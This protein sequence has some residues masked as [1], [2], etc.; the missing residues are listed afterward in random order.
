LSPLDK[1]VRREIAAL[2]FLTLF[3]SN[4]FWLA[5]NVEPVLASPAL[6]LKWIARTPDGQRFV[7][8]THIG[9]L[10]ANLV[11]DNKLEIVVTGTGSDGTGVLAAIDGTTGT[12]LWQKKNSLIHTHCPFD[13]VDLN[14]D[15]VP[16]IIVSAW[17][18]YVY[19]GN[20]GSIYWSN[21]AKAYQNY[22]AIL[23]ID[24]DSYSEVFVSSGNGKDA[25]YDYITRLSYDGNVLDQAWCW[26]PCWGGV[27]IGDTNFDGRF[28]LYQGDRSDSYNPSGDP[29]KGGGMGVRALDA[30]TLEPLWNDPT[31]LC[32]SQA[33]MLADVDK[34]GILDVIVNMQTSSGIAVLNSADGSVVTT[35]GIYRKGVIASPHP[36]HSQPTVYDIDGDGNL[37]LIDCVYPDGSNPKIWDLYDWKLDATLP[38]VCTEP[39]KIGEVTGDGK[40][41]IIAVTD[42]E[43]YVY[44]YIG[45]N[46]IQVDYTSQG[47]SW[48]TNDFTLV[49]DVDGDNLNE[50]VLTS[51]S[52]YVYCYDTP[53]P[54]PTPRARSNLQFY[55]EYR[56]GAAEYVTPPTPSRPTLTD[57]QPPDGSRNQMLN[58]TLS[59]H[60]TDFQGNLMDIVIRTNASGTWEDIAS[61]TN[62]GNGMYTATPSEMDDGGTTYYWSVNATNTVTGKWTSKTYSFTTYSNAPTHTQPL[63]VSSGGTNGNKDDLTCYNQSTTDPDGNEVTNIYNWYVNDTSLTNLLL[64]FDTN[65]EPSGLPSLTD[66]FEYG[67]GNWDGNGITSWVRTTSQKHSGSYSAQG[68][69]RSDTD[70]TSDDLDASAAEWI[71]VSFWYRDYG[72]D[73]WDLVTLQFWNGST[74]RDILN[75]GT[76][77]P[78]QQWHRYSVW[79][80]TL[81]SYQIPDFHIRFKATDISNND[82]T[83]WVDDVSITLHSIGG[84]SASTK[85]YSGYNN[86]GEV[87]GATWTSEGVIGGAYV[88]DGNDRIT[89]N[90]NGNSLGGDGSWSEISVEFW[91]RATQETGTEYL[92]WKHAAAST[93]TVGYR[94]EFQAYSDTV[95]I[96]WRVY[97]PNTRTVYYYIDV[98]P[99]SW[100]H[101][102]C[103]YKSGVEQRIYVDGIER[104]SATYTG[105]I[106][107]TLGGPIQIG[108]SSG[109]GDFAGMLDEVRIYPRALTSFQ[110]SQRFLETKDGLSSNS[111]ILWQETKPSELW[112]CQVTPNDGLIDGMS[113]FSNYATVNYTNLPPAAANPRILPSPPTSLDDLVAN[114]DYSDPDGDPEYRSRIRWYRD[115][116]LQSAFNNLRTVPASS[117]SRGQNWYFTV[118][119]SDSL[120]FGPLVTS[121]TVTIQNAPPSIAGVY[122]TPDPAF[123]SSD[124]TANP[125]G[126]FD[127][128]NDPAAYTYKWQILDNGNWVDIPGQTSSTLGSSYSDTGDRLKVICTPF[129]G[130]NEGSAR[131]NTRWIISPLTDPLLISSLGTNTTDEY[132]TCYNHTSAT[133]TTNIYNWYVNGVPFANL[134]MPFN[135]NNP[136]TAT[137][138][139]GYSN[140]GVVSGATW[141]SSGIEGGAYNFD[142]NDV[143]TVADSSSLGN[144][145]T[146]SE[147]TLEYWVNPSVDQRG[148]RILNKNGGNADASGKYMTGF[149][150]AATGPTNVVF[151]GIIIGGSYVETYSDT[152]TKIPSGSW[153]HIVATYK[154]G[155]GIKIYI[156]G[157]LKSANLGV[158]GNIDSSVGEPLF[159]GYS[160]AIGGTAN[161]YL[162][163]RLDDVRIYDRALSPE[164]ALQRYLDSKDGLIGS[165]TIVAEETTI[166]EVWKC[167]V[168]P[169]TGSGDGTAKFSNTLTVIEASET[170]TLTVNVVGSGSVN[171]NNT[172]PYYYG[173]VVELTAVAD[174]GWSFKNWSV[175]LSGSAN[176]ETITMDGDKV[177]NATFIQLEYTLAINVFGNGSVTKDPD[178][179]NYTYG[180]EV[181]L[182]AVADLGW[183]FSEWTGDLSGSKNPTTITMDGNKT[184]NATF[185]LNE[186]P[187]IDSYYPIGDP[188]ITE[189]ESQLFNVTY[190]DADGNPLT[191]QWYL[192][193]T[194]TSTLDNYTFVGDYDSA[195]VYNVTV[196]V[197]DGL[198][199]DSYEWTLTVLDVNRDP[200]IDDYYPDSDPIIFEGES[201]EFN[202]TYSDPDGDSVTV[203]WYLNGT[204]TSTA[205]SYIFAANYNSAGVYNVTV[206]ISDGLAQESHEW[207]LTVVEVNMPPTI[208][209]YYPLS[210]PTI[211]EGESQ[212][213][214]VTYHDPDGD[215]VT[216]QWYLNGTPTVTTDSY[217]FVSN[218]DSAG[219]YNVTVVISD[220]LAQ[221]SYEW[222]LTVLNVNR[223]P[224]ID[225]YTPAETNPEVNEGASLNFTHVSSDPD[226]DPLSYS[227]LLDGVE[228]TTTQNWTYSP[229]Y[230]DAGT[231]NITLVVSDGELTDS[232]Q[233]NVTVNDVNR[234]PIIDSYYPPTNPTVGEGESQLF[235][236]TYS[237]PDGDPLTVQWLL[238]GTIVGS[239]DNF[240]YTADY[241]SAGVYNVTV[242]VSDGF[243]QTSLEWTLTVLIANRAPV[244]DDYYPLSD[245]TIL[246]GESQEFN[247]TYHDPDGDPVTVQWL[248]N[249]TAVGSNNNYTFT[250]DYDSAGIYNVTVVV[251]DGLE[252]ASHE[253]FL[254]VLNVNRPPTIDSYTPTDLEPQ[255]DEGD[256]LDFTHTSSDPDGDPLSY[257]W[258]LDGVEQADKQNWTYTPGYGDAGFHNV[259]LVVSDGELTDSQQWNVSVNDVNRPPIIDTYY[260]P[261]DPTIF[262]GQNQE[263]NVTYHDPDGGSVTVQWYLNGTPTSTADNYT[264]TASYESA[265][266]YNI[267]VVISD[268]LVQESHEWTLTVVEFNRPPV[269]DDYYPLTD[270]AILENEHQEFNVTYHDPDGDALTVGWYLN[271]SLVSTLDNYTFSAG[272]HDAGVY[273]VTV[274]V[275]DALA[276]TSYEWTLTVLDVNRPPTIDSFTPEDLEPE[277]DEGDSLEFAHTSSDPDDDILTYSWLLDGVEQAN[278]QN[279]TYSPDFEDAGTHNVTL[280]VSDGELTDSQQ[281]SVTVMNINKAPVINTFY[282][283]TDP[284]INESE[285]Q[286]FNITYSDLD[287]DILWVQ[288]YLNG[289]P[290]VTADSYTFVADYDSAGIYNVTVVVSDGLAQASHEW[291]LTILNV[292]RPPVIDSYTPTDLEP[293]VYEGASLNFTHTSSDPDGDPLS[294]SWLL[295]GVEQATSQ[296]WTY[297]P[298]YDAAGTHNVTLTVSDGEFVVS[299]QWNVTVLNIN[300]A[301]VIDSY[302]PLSNPTILEGESQYF[303]VTYHDVDGDALTVQWLLNGSLVGSL[304][305]YT[306]TAGSASA[307]VYNVTVVVSDGGGLVDSQQWNLIVVEMPPVLFGDGFESGGFSAWDSTTSGGNG[308]IAVDSTIKHHGSYSSKSSWSTSGDTAYATKSFAAT[309]LIYVRLYFNIATLPQNGAITRFLLIRSGNAEV[310]QIGLARSSGGVLYWTIRYRNNGVVSTLSYSSLPYAGEWVCIEFLVDCSSANGQLDGNYRFYVN[311]VEIWN[312]LNVDTD[313]TS[314]DSIR[315]GL[316]STTGGQTNSIHV[317]CVVVADAYIGPETTAT[318]VH[319]ESEEIGASSSNR[320]FITFDGTSY[321]LPSDVSKATGVYSAGYFADEGYVFDH[322]VTTGLISVTSANANPTTVTVSGNGM[323][324][325]IYRTYTPVLFGDGFE[326]GGF[327]A[328]DSTTSGGNGVIAVDSTIKHHG[329]YSSKSSWSASG[330]TAYATKSFAATD[331][332]YVRLY[333]NIATL[334]Q[335]GAIT[336]FLLIRSGNAEVGQIGLA[337][338]SGGVLYWTIRY[339]NNGVVSTLSYSSLPYAGEWVCIEFLVDCS[340]ANGQLDGNYR[341]YVNGVEIWNALNVDTDATSV[342][343]IRVGLISTTDG[344]TNSVYV[345][346][347]VVAD[348]YIGPE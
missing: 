70:L 299:Q 338:S 189:E 250:A 148:A 199:Q 90:E 10:A 276:V 168:T 59:I 91:V 222:S 33:P 230:E 163:G 288:W 108:Y 95:Y 251:S 346:C 48:G 205:D 213:F 43:I 239:D 161:R 175:D 172:G 60:A 226:G 122:I 333:F 214:N 298:S 166:G 111:T 183:V 237:D 231:H 281:W 80:R 156:N 149:N 75:L 234:P 73:F 347:V 190:S 287:G 53:A 306:F 89:V 311:G 2:I 196:V 192:N 88:F 266:T 100:H 327:S 145:G 19:H 317:D 107:A 98:G 313:A 6:T 41:D 184:V 174:L 26:H 310:G 78:E 219:I 273:N 62:V 277:V 67:F 329:S 212:E 118:E 153:S 103:T 348:T 42:H 37:E 216:V 61:Y 243:N 124:L 85:D 120:V 87:R 170:Y 147:I 86:H 218:Y 337:R 40:M 45:G 193:G 97:N 332:I 340:S 82:E 297:S 180:T 304:D 142:G 63:L 71:A 83:F 319:L 69:G 255:V 208:D 54:A 5:M 109:S 171:L 17:Y 242:V 28:E 143:I 194:P 137:D 167:L 244:I 3:L 312:A 248:L 249:G 146:W 157:V 247:V 160:S 34:D 13:I 116:V 32:S 177:V 274:V 16:E 9:A 258:L 235:N 292:N 271:G 334:P 283:L 131:E 280:V 20:D 325:A 136:S 159:I 7:A 269:I 256:S 128:D 65:P 210:D 18:T 158:T 278:T 324:I 291:T 330:D 211:S 76:T 94:V 279:W 96:R 152:Y 268:G 58:P 125:Y 84:E 185:T 316:I 284:T 21:Y 253:W 92:I 187:A 162:N 204:P 114:Y 182:T 328:W 134:L 173:D 254:T 206:L 35:G 115:G 263:F 39:P 121:P 144:D 117:I 343:S 176:P 238:N 110:V 245:L 22:N 246:E 68:S 259:T 233:W 169:N 323:L 181:N 339:R 267:T 335:N 240:T 225:S 133:A 207:V 151:F 309:D 44:S 275:S 30:H 135:T 252:K 241:D 56:L 326:S 318:T 129:D 155:E 282:P 164:Q 224:T 50:L 46:Y 302:Y 272:Y 202:V 23:D 27:T 66:G 99:R 57:E 264:F 8:K 294:Y 51:M 14:K 221:A 93:S 188:T 186:P 178:Q 215:P 289:T 220:G 293:E 77:S 104:V 11:G 36:S 138:Y 285:S 227:W 228:Q 305:N 140:N 331:L 29:Y 303:N 123:D 154:S 341:F 265:G 296:N 64:P 301:P 12:V 209:S 1:R 4:V 105:N 290:T 150:T 38:V 286:E 314:V 31:I 229:S 262:E 72:I 322:W 200:T 344:Q 52:G 127:K 179:L 307:G 321:S 232:Q 257:S 165:S 295:D 55:S 139:S 74:Y 260:P 201:Q 308:V 236:V 195:G 223:P 197:S 81:F 113:K 315:V 24:G 300:R 79:Y 198:A 126:W 191:V 119:P 132:L 112:R 47:L 345:D 130:A 270:P 141:T 336:R 342:D 217:T 320:G 15:G 203:Q 25:G 106:R 49:Q 102:V 101:V 261:T